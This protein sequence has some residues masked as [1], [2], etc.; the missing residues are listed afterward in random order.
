MKRMVAVAVVLCLAVVGMVVVVNLQSWGDL[1][2]VVI[3]YPGGDE[4]RITEGPESVLDARWTPDGESIVAIEANARQ[5][6]LTR[7]D[8]STGKRRERTE[9]PKGDEP[10]DGQVMDVGP[11]GEVVVVSSETPPG[12]AAV[13]IWRR[14]AGLEVIATIPGGPANPVPAEIFISP[15]GSRIAVPFAEEIRIVMVDGSGHSR[16]EHDLGAAE[17]IGWTADGAGLYV[18]PRMATGLVRVLELSLRTGLASPAFE[19]AGEFHRGAAVSPDGRLLAAVV[20]Y[21][22]MII[23]RAGSGRV[24]TEQYTQ[25]AVQPEWSPSGMAVAAA[26][27]PG[28]AV[29]DLGTNETQL[30]LMHDDLLPF[31]V[32]WSADGERI[33]VT[34]RR[35]IRGD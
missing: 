28:L 29:Y 25:G 34:T 4:R 1:S 9:I 3:E 27:D 26:L 30:F 21:R 18:V 32:S 14:G 22:L 2:L 12:T 24:V 5:V 20:D 23:D 13:S 17:V 7:F 6:F 16:L 8:A 10:F 35:A 11:G 19:Y 31:S 15:D 33:A